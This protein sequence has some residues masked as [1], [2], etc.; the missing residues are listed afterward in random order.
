M[1]FSPLGKGFL[2]GAMDEKTTF[3]ATDFRT[4]L[5][6][7]TPEARVANGALVAL[8]RS[9]GERTGATPAQVALGWLLAQRPWIVPI[10]GTRR[11]ERL[12]ENMAATTLD[13]SPED[14]RE[15]ESAAARI[16]IEGAR[17]PESLERLTGR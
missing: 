6:R 9:I 2:T 7:F 10:P 12:D 8:M 14:L 5:P 16:T 11:L 15:I 3:D 4:T 1:P 17:Y 13:L